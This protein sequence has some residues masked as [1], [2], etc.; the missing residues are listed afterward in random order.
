MNTD[1]NTNIRPIK[2]E[3]VRFPRQTTGKDDICYQQ[4]K[5]KL[6]T[7]GENC[8][9][10]RVHIVTDRFLS[11]HFQKEIMKDSK[12]FPMGTYPYVLIVDTSLCNL[13]CRACY[14]SKY[15]KPD[16]SADPT[17]VTPELLAKQFKCKIEKLHD[18]ELVKSRRIGEKTK[19]PFSRL[20]ISGGE[21]LFSKDGGSIEFWLSFFESLD[22]EFD[23]LII[24]Q[25][26][27]LKTEREWLSMSKEERENNFPIFLKSDNSKIRIRFD[28]NSWL[29]K[30][31]EFTEK[32]IVGIY[33]LKLENIKIDL[34]LSLKGTNWYEVEWFIN[35]VS[36]VE[37][38]KLN[39]DEQIEKH[40]QWTSLN[41]IVETIKANEDSEILTKISGNI[42]SETYF[43]PCGEVSLTIEK[44]IMNNPRERLYLYSKDSL[45]W[46]HFVQKLD[47]KGLNLSKTENRIYLGQHPYNTAR[48]YINTGN[49]ELRFKCALHPDKPF[50]SYSKKEKSIT[51]S[52]KHRQ[53]KGYSD[54]NLKHF[55][56]RLED[57]NK[58]L[59]SKCIGSDMICDHCSKCIDSDMI[60][61]HWIEM[62]PISPF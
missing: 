32:F 40:P 33:D 60:C 47:E 31:K 12:D 29:F 15:W 11:P 48:R 30:N 22:I 9:N 1:E 21:P 24:T 8:S 38:D 46:D 27:T 59:G 19:R 3:V 28:T 25:K 41:N 51:D 45:N 23:D 34:T 35:H 2:K 7:S 49:Y 13:R 26:V 61:D 16:S 39:Y 6:I 57:L 54:S 36:T 37:E 43:N 5:F 42:I 4:N 10:C 20:R 52:I 55:A 18:E 62:L 17:L 58:N 56:D 50:L 53:I 44:G 14:S